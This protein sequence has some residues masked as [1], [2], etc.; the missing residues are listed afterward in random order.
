MDSEDVFFNDDKNAP[1]FGHIDTDDVEKEKNVPRPQSV[2]SFIARHDRFG[3]RALK[4]REEDSSNSSD[5]LSIQEDLKF[6][7]SRAQLE[8]HGKQKH[9]RH[10]SRNF[11]AEDSFQKRAPLVPVTFDEVKLLKND[12]EQKR[13]HLHSK[14]KVRRDE[15]EEEEEED[16]DEDDPK[17]ASDLRSLNMSELNRLVEENKSKPKVTGPIFAEIARREEQQSVSRQESASLA[18]TQITSAT[19]KSKKEDGDDCMLCKIGIFVLMGEF[20]PTFRKHEMHLKKM[21]QSLIFGGST[22]KSAM[23]HVAKY[24]NQ[25]LRP[26][27]MK[28]RKENFPLQTGDSVFVHLKEHA[29]EVTMWQREQVD[30]I[31]AL[32]NQAVDS[33]CKRDPVDNS[34]ETDPIQIRSYRMLCELGAYMR[35]M[36]TT[37][38][39][40]FIPG[41]SVAPGENSS[42]MASRAQDAPMP[43]RPKK[44]NF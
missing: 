44:M 18:P 6:A 36:D 22:V 2:D 31:Q 12:E 3:E 21:I 40:G 13:K 9:K 35:K 8:K 26:D 33:I 39:A 1:T 23:K 38:M 5:D 19:T 25:H 37:R 28:I 29:G 32:T 30:R 11:Q 10:F 27:Y 43:K 42:N 16:D 20:D 14:R 24:I 7:Q 34:I 41:L 17:K 15:E 4:E